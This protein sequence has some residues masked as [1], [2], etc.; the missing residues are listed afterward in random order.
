MFTPFCNICPVNSGAEHGNRRVSLSLV[1]IQRTQRA[2]RK[3]FAYCFDATQATQAKYASKYVINAMNSRKIR[4]KSNE[5]C[6][7][8]RRKDRSGVYFFSLRLLRWMET[9]FRRCERNCRPLLVAQQCVARLLQSEL[10]QLH[11]Q[12]NEMTTMSG[13]MRNGLAMANI[14]LDYV[15]RDN[16]QSTHFVSNPL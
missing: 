4:N 6:W 16:L 15:C 14:T 7:R 10:C 13:E 5:R 9:S 2:E 3:A 1:F 8:K 12:D 11:Q